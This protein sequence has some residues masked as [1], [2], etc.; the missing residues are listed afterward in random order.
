MHAALIKLVEESAEGVLVL[1]ED[2]GEA[3][4]LRSRLTRQEVRKLL[5]SVAATMQAMPPELR[6]AMPELAW[7]GWERL[8]H[9]L[10]A[11]PPAGDASAWFAV[12]SLVPATLSWLRVYRQEQPAL[13][14]LT[15]APP[16]TAR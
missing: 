10:K 6:R 2:L 14:D 15:A 12:Q 1:V 9:D 16:S 4:F 8:G 11:A 3:E 5:A 13:F 7:D